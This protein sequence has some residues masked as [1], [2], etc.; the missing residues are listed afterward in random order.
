MHFKTVVYFIVMDLLK[1]K[2]SL[3]FDFILSQNLKIFNRNILPDCV[4][5][6]VD[7]NAHINTW[8]HTGININMYA[9]CVCV[10]QHICTHRRTH[11]ICVFVCVSVYL[12]ICKYLS[13]YLSSY[14]DLNRLVTLWTRLRQSL[15]EDYPQ[16]KISGRLWLDPNLYPVVRFQ[17]WNSEECEV[18]SLQPFLPDPL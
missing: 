13:I 10:Y 8:I 1:R 18:T 2:L 7:A 6:D 14:I 4:W 5:Q 15:E 17:F 12:R 3:F 9:V 16:Q 11:C